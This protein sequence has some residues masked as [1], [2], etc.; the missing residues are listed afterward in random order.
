MIKR[1]LISCFCLLAGL[2]LLAATYPA[3]NGVFTYYGF[4]TT[5]SGGAYWST[6]ISSADELAKTPPVQVTFTVAGTSFSFVFS[7]DPF[8]AAKKTTDKI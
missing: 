4:P 5:N 7:N 1:F 3:S 2:P 8:E 6:G